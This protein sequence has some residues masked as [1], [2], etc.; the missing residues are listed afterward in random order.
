MAQQVLAHDFDLAALGVTPQRNTTAA[1]A[2]FPSKTTAPLLGQGLQAIERTNGGYVLRQV[3]FAAHVVEI[4][5]RIE[6]E[7]I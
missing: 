5:A 6:A 1:P 3:G 2:H 4:A 7:P